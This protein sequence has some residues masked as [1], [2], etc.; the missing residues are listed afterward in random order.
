MLVEAPKVRAQGIF[1]FYGINK[2]TGHVRHLNSIAPNVLSTL[3]LNSW[4][5]VQN[6]LL[7][8]QVGTAGTPLPSA[9]D[10]ALQQ[11]VASSDNIQESLTF[12][13]TSAPYF[14]TKQL[15]WRYDAGTT[16]GNLAETSASLGLLS[17]DQAI[18]RGLIVNPQTGVPTTVSPLP[19]EILDVTYQMRYYPPTGDQTGSVTLDGN[20]Y[21]YIIRAANV[22]SPSSWAQYIGQEVGA[23]AGTD[24]W[25][26]YSG[27]ISADITG[28]PSG[29]TA[30]CDNSNQTEEAYSVG[31]FQRTCVCNTGPN[32]WNVVGGIKSL[33][34]QTTLGQYQMSFDPVVPKTTGKLMGIGLTVGWGQH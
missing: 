4:A 29:T 18:S 25:V 23:V 17:S 2:F 10:N 34:M 3:G 21:N 26:A 22:T 15:R 1:N 13:E 24:K 27:D 20:S 8:N 33:L 11:W 7:Y 14:A 30:Q 5:Q 12:C 19:D 16:A 32:G 9:A 31:S 6:W 28:Q